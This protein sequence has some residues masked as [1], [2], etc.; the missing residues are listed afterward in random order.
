MTMVKLTGFS[1]KGFSLTLGLGLWIS[2]G[3]VSAVALAQ[4]VPSP[5]PSGT[6]ALDWQRYAIKGEEFSVLLPTLPAMTTLTRLFGPNQERLERTIGSY[7]N[8]VV[9]AVHTFHF[10]NRRQS[11]EEIMTEFPRSAENFK[12]E[13]NVGKIHGR[14]YRF[15]TNEVSGVTQFYLTEKNI[16]VFEVLGSSLGDIQVGISRFLDSIKFGKTPDGQHLVDGPGAQPA[17]PPLKVDEIFSGRVV[18][19][20]ARII[21]KPEPAYTERA[22]QEGIT[23]TVVIKCVFSSSG[24]VTNIVAVS[25]LPDGLTEKAIAAAQQI[26]FIPAVKDGRF[27]SMYMQLEYNFNLY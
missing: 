18:T 24:T 13:L 15:Q 26:R 27:V 14:E 4:S 17:S 8:G 2:T 16:Y 11:L 22:R 12:R 1:M 25:K 3:F 10:P 19:S 6:E 9:Y 20:K 5:I 23:G 7:S 21:T